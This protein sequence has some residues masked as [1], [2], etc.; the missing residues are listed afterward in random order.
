MANANIRGNVGA[1]IVFDKDISQDDQFQQVKIIYILELV[2][3]INV[4]LFCVAV[5]TCGI[6]QLP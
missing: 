1:E 3:F 5:A 2:L 6:G 4:K